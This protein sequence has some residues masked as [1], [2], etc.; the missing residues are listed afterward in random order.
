VGLRGHSLPNLVAE[1]LRIAR[2]AAGDKNVEVFA[3]TIGRRLLERGLIDE[4]DLRIA[5]VL[6]GDGIRLFDNAGG[7]PVQLELLTGKDRRAAVDARYPPTTAGRS[8]H[9]PRRPGN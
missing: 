8:P 6:L 2:K 1:A 7:A 3:T 5:P 9:T 4:I